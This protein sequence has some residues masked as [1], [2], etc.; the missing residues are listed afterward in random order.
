[1][2][3]CNLDYE[4]NMLLHSLSLQQ[5]G[6]FE[7]AKI[8]F[9]DPESV[10]SLI[11][12]I[13]GDNGSGKSIIIDSIRALLLGGYGKIERVITKEDNFLANLEF[14]VD[15]KLGTIKTTLTSEKSSQGHFQVNSSNYNMAFHISSFD[16]NEPY[17]WMLDYWTPRLSS[18][19]SSSIGGISGPNFKTYMNGSLSGNYSNQSLI[20]WITFF[21]YLKGSENTKE[22]EAGE[23]MFNGIKKII[24][25]AV[26][27][28]YLDHVSRTNFQPI[29]NVNGRHLEI[30]QLSSGNQYIIQKLISILYKA[31]CVQHINQNTKNEIDDVFNVP[32]VLLIDEIENHLHPKWQKIILST[33]VELFPKLQIIATTHSPFV[34]ASVENANIF[35]CQVKD[36]KS[37]IVDETDTYANQPIDEILATDLFNTLPFNTKITNLLEKRKRLVEDGDQVERQRVEKELLELNPQYFSF[38]SFFDNYDKRI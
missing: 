22:M 30:S 18:D 3:Y 34:V 29:I 24:T 7:S 12:L 26:K 1:V 14:T 10:S 33:I 8:Q 11:T 16:E 36:G 13:T 27:D 9:N 21:D 28:G 37:I 17:T 2:Y 6:P 19:Q 38:F 31:Y 15:T 25:V 4:L 20:Q 32:G 5:V 23:A 35:V